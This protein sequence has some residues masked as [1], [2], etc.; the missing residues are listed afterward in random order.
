[1]RNRISSVLLLSAL[2]LSGSLGGC[3]GDGNDVGI[4]GEPLPEWEAIADDNLTYSKSGMI[5]TKHLI[6]FSASWCT[7]CRDLMHKVTGEISDADYLVISTDS[8]DD[9]WEELK[10]WHEQ[11][12]GANDSHDVNAPFMSESVLANSVDIRNTPTIF[13]IDANGIIISKQIGNFD[14]TQEIHDFW[15]LA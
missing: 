2:L 7:P 5:G 12:N 13:L 9:N 10:D 14:G 1:M 11:V 8:N 4:E 6:H 3:L 15:N